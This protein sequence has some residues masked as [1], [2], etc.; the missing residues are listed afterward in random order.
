MEG[1]QM[2]NEL[3]TSSVQELEDKIKANPDDIGLKEELAGALV[4][5]YLGGEEGSDPGNDADVARL[6]TILA[7]LPKEKAPYARAY[8][9]YLDEKDDEAADWLIRWTKG[10]DAS[11]VPEPLTADELQVDVIE[12]F[13][14]APDEF[15]SKLTNALEQLWAQSPAALTLRGYVEQVDKRPDIAIDY[16][17]LALGKDKEY[18]VAAWG[19]GECHHTKKNWE[20]ASQCY[21]RAL[22]SKVGEV[23]PD[24][25][26]YAAWCFGK[27]GK[28]TQEE[29]HYR[30]CL[31]LDSEFEFARNN[32]GW[33]LYRQRRFEAALEVFEECIRRKIAGTYPLRN[34]AK[35]LER[36]GKLAE[37]IEAWKQTASRGR[38]S[39]YAQERI[40]KLQ[41]RINS[42]ER[43]AAATIGS[44]DEEES[45]DGEGYLDRKR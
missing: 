34:K 36:L 19:L 31:E 18:W 1:H 29:T 42:G 7:D 10:G 32:L 12:P 5:R 35:T 25:H 15:W 37:A 44:E 38:L 2:S 45:E 17:E 14:G 6:R 30:R 21:N 11:K 9:A 16:Y 39:K 24:L 8:V 20:A 41:N 27:L 4:E 13:T 22:E 23:I 26:F 3:N 28:Y 40:A 43:T 33:A